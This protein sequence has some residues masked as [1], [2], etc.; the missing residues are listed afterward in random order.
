MISMNF[1]GK[2]LRTLYNDLTK[3]VNKKNYDFNYTHTNKRVFGSD[4]MKTGA[5]MMSEVF[6]Q[7]LMN[8]CDMVFKITRN[9]I[10]LY[11]AWE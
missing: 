11:V 5:N 2:Q 3:P 1:G 9:N 8:S 4:F 6:K 10:L 7:Y